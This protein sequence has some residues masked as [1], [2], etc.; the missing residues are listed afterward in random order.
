MCGSLAG[1]LAVAGCSSGAGKRATQATEP[2]A[3]PTAAVQ[4]VACNP[5]QLSV[6]V[7]Q[8]AAGAFGILAR[9]TGA[10]CRLVGRPDVQGNDAQGQRVAVAHQA[11]IG[12]RDFVITHG[13]AAVSWMTINVHRTSCK[14]EIVGLAIRISTKW[15]PILMRGRWSARPSANHPYECL[16]G[17]AVSPQQPYLVSTTGWQR[18]PSA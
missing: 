14:V 7:K 8:Y 10:R 2:S 11:S 12:R 6:A 15:R 13:A 9:N 16:R 3:S 1:L 5:H 4:V 17:P 18:A